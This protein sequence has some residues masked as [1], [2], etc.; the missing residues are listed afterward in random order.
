MVAQV[1]REYINFGFGK[2]VRR[3]TS[4]ALFEGRPATTKGQWFNPIVFGWLKL[5]RSL[6]RSIDKVDR[7]IFI[8]GL[9]RSGT[10]ILGILLSL[11]KDVGFLNEP[12]AIWHVI[13]PKQDINGNYSREGGYYR[14]SR[15]DVTDHARESAHRIY[16]RYAQVTGVKRILDKYPELI[17]R[18]EYVRELFP[19]SKIIFIA[20]NGVDACESIVKWSQRLGVQNRGELEDW[21]GRNDCKWE[22]FR[23][24]LVIGDP[25]Y[26]SV[27]RLVTSDL[28][29]VNRAALEWLVTMREG[30]RCQAQYPELMISVKYEDLISDPVGELER[31]Q[32]A[33]GLEIDPDVLSYAKNKLYENPA[34]GWPKLLPEIESLFADTMEMMGYDPDNYRK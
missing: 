17:F 10:T 20:R 4:Y 9:G 32:M 27:K 25:Q 28:D 33:C 8:T 16:S 26:G 5:L 18:V 24:E 3:L 6:P 14:L 2:Y 1:D 12:K 31:L 11:N 22:Y 21:W 7:P 19:D 15:N 23:N 34:K 30:M 13:D 29:H